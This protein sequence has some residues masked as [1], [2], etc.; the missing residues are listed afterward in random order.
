MNK[1]DFTVDLKGQ[2]QNW[3][4]WD[5]ETPGTSKPAEDTLFEK[6]VL[7]FTSPVTSCQPTSAAEADYFS[8]PVLSPDGLNCRFEKII[9]KL[10]RN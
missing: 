1:V 5:I 7:T 6:S 10:Q 4:I 8:A 3:A 9:L 2:D